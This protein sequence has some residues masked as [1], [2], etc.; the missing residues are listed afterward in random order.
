MCP[1]NPLI[2]KTCTFYHPMGARTNHDVRYLKFN[3]Q[4]QE[5][6]TFPYNIQELNILYHELNINYKDGVIWNLKK[7]VHLIVKIVLSCKM[8]NKNNFCI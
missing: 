4:H 7:K 6:K 5:E 2:L 8:E 3:Q 1:I